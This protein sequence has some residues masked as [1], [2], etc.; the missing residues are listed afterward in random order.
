MDNANSIEY[1]NKIRDQLIENLSRTKFGPSVQMTDT[2]RDAEG[3][4]DEADAAMDDEDEDQNKDVRMTQHRWDKQTERDGELS[5]SED[6]AENERN[7]VVNKK[8]TRRRNMM[9]YQ[10]PNAVPDI[11]DSGVATPASA[12]N[13]DVPA[14][15]ANSQL[16]EELLHAKAASPNGQ[17]ARSPSVESQAGDVQMGEDTTT[18]ALATGPEAPSNTQQPA[19]VPLDVDMAEDSGPTQ[20]TIGQAERTL[21]DT[22]GEARAEAAS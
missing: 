12:L 20:K 7:G 13:G 21:A 16:Q 10:N 19:V 6:E 14:L 11:D 8:P 17:S 1:L 2:P 5:E 18:T 4:D 9:D 15:A 3:F 22:E